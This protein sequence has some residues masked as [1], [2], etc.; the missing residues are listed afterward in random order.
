MKNILFFLLFLFLSD[1]VHAQELKASE[2][3][4]LINLVVTNLEEEP[5]SNE[6]VFFVSAD[7]EVEVNVKTDEQGKAQVLLPKGKTY[8]IKYKDLIEKIKYSSFEIPG[9]IGKYSFDIKI[10]FEPS[11]IVLLKGVRF[12]EDGSVDEEFAM[13]LDMMWQVLE[14][15]P[16]MEIVVVVHS[17]NSESESQS[18]IK[19]KKQA[20]AI[21]KYLV[22]KGIAESRIKVKGMGAA[23]PIALNALPEGRARNN[24]IEIRVIKKYL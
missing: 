7:K 6:L 11:D 23:E 18:L 9:G 24:R 17:D 2:F 8:N 10:K 13:E 22:D 20:V 4:A 5:L 21:K 19:T 1:F 15:N 14:L 16:K 3:K 12:N